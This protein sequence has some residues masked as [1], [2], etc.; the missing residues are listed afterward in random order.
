M[1]HHEHVISQSAMEQI[2]K[3]QANPGDDEWGKT[4][5]FDIQ[6]E[7]PNP[8]SLRYLAK[9]ENAVMLQLSKEF[10]DTLFHQL[11]AVKK[12]LGSS[13]I[14]LWTPERFYLKNVHEQG[15][16]KAHHSATLVVTFGVFERFLPALDEYFQ[17]DLL[18][19]THPSWKL[20]D[21]LR[22]ARVVWKNRCRCSS[23]DHQERLRL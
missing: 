8:Q 4:F 10:A 13:S 18:E 14:Q 11:N 22:T 6:I 23:A 19:L 15:G 17:D 16:R 5:L 7:V 12:D 9:E 3:F 21:T 1:Y 20:P 2:E